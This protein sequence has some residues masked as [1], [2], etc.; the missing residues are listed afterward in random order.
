LVAYVKNNIFISIVKKLSG[1]F[2]FGFYKK[3]F[4]IFNLED[5]LM[6]VIRMSE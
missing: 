4:S 6:E 5:L 1:G 2:C 3:L